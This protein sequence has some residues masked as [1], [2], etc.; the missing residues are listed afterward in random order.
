M[1]PRAPFVTAPA[2]NGRT[3]PYDTALV[4]RRRDRLLSARNLMSV[5]VP[6]PHHARLLHQ[7]L[8]AL[9]L[10]TGAPASAGAQASWRQ[11]ADITR[12][13]V[14]IDSF[15]VI[16]SG[17]TIGW[18]RLGWTKDG[19]DWVMSDEVALSGV[20]QRS[21]IR[22]SSAL[23]EQGLRQQGTMGSTAMKITLDR[24]DGRLRGTAL[25]PS[26]G[27]TPAV[28]E[29]NADDDVIDDNALSV[30]LPLI[31]WRDG[32]T[33][34]VPVLSSGKGSS[35]HFAASVVG[36]RTVVVPAGSFEVWQVALTG[37]R[38]VLEADVTTAPPYRLVRF[39]PRG[40]A[41]SSQL[42]H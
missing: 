3:S 14:A 1:V 32:L 19:A 17:R 30:I 22:F 16:V 20:A 13:R 23:V 38:Y 21:E 28:I 2:T 4:I 31:R 10:W 29:A 18:Q 6:S 12:A 26:G 15:S 27:P 7:L 9:V 37:A 42:V 5:S 40:A 41:M 33:F 34:D 39:G 11:H 35:E 25:T 8:V 24:I 36:K